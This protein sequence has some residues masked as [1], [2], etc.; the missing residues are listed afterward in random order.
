MKTPMLE[1]IIQK[2]F[3]RRIDGRVRAT[4]SAA[5]TENQFLAGVSSGPETLRDRYACGRNE[6]FEHALEA[7][8]VNPLA[9]RIVELTTQ[10]VVGGGLA[11]DCKDEAAAHFLHEIWD[12]PLNQLEVRTGEWCDELSRT[13]NLFI[14][15]STDPAGMTYFRA[16]PA[17]WIERIESAANDTDQELNFYPKASLQDLNPRPW[18]ACRPDADQ[19]LPGT[20]FGTVMVHYAVNRPVGARWGESDLAPLLKWF[21]RYANWLEDRARLNRFRT[22]FLYVVKTRFTSEAE[23]SARQ[24]TLNASQPKPGSILVTDE[25]ED[26]SVIEPGLAGAD[27]MNDGLAL[28]KMIAAGSGLPMHFLAEPEGATRTTAEAAG[29]PTYRRFEQRQKY[30]LWLVH[31]LL[32]IALRRRAQTDRSLNPEAE[33]QVKGADIS[34]RDNVSLAAAVSNMVNGLGKLRSRGLI[35]DAE[36][37]RLVYRFAGETVDVEAMLRRGAA[38]GPVSGPAWQ[39]EGRAPSEKIRMDPLTGEPVEQAMGSV[40]E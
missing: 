18:P 20:G 6:V 25:S 28:K 26:W 9:R 32:S 30:F 19:P 11:F 23:R 22:A 13:G 1:Q 39:E 17:A 21:S 3:G 10:Y 12:H 16:V 15:L 29:G 2:V 14:L 35:D 37:L 7:W 8:R 24:R 4:L 27:A 40:A 38:A 5:E 36:Y 31:N 33:F 34:A